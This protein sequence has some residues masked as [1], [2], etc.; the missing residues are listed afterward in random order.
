MYRGERFN[1]YSHLAG[2]VLAAA[3]MAVLVTSS[4]LHHIYDGFTINPGEPNGGIGSPHRAQLEA[5]L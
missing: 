5:D 1:G 4:A 2:A 3:G